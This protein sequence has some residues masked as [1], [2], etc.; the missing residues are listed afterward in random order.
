M[1]RYE[2]ILDKIYFEK[3]SYISEP[4]T[5]A[6]PGQLLRDE[7]LKMTVVNG[8]WVKQM[9]HED[10]EIPSSCYQLKADTRSITLFEADEMLPSYYYFDFEL[11][12]GEVSLKRRLGNEVA[13][14]KFMVKG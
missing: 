13:W 9:M 3:E 10:G 8:E 12:E 11:S 7:S 4:I 2:K 6:V 14:K 5:L 1:Y